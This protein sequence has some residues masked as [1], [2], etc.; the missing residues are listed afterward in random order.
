M[1]V[2]ALIPAFNEAPTVATVVAGVRPLVSQV[3]VVDDGSTDATVDLA[4]QAGA[5][6]VVQG[7]NLGCQVG[8]D[9]IRMLPVRDISLSNRCTKHNP[10]HQRPIGPQDAYPDE[11]PEVWLFNRTALGNE[12]AYVR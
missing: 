2:A 7:R 6:V 5:D 10:C 4:R 1:R 9:R 11:V 3:F 12:P 8:R